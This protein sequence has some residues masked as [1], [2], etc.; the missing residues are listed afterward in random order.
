MISISAL[1]LLLF[2][3]RVTSLQCFPVDEGR[4][5]SVAQNCML[6]ASF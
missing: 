4:A 2:M 1:F 3:S 5:I 6:E